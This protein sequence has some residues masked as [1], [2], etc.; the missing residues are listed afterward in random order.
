MTWFAWILLGGAAGWASSILS[1]RNAGMSLIVNIVIGIL[2]A[3]I[4]NFLFNLITGS[5]LIGFSFNITTLLVAIGGA[6]VLLFL[7]SFIFKKS[8][9]SN[10][11]TM[12]KKPHERRF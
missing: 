5:N 2:G 10:Q 8:D 11:T 1:N 9:G 7:F 12:D 6:T 3:F 4:G